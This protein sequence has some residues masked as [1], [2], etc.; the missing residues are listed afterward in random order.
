[1]EERE[2]PNY[3]NDYDATGNQEEWHK[4][5]PLVLWIIYFCESVGVLYFVWNITIFKLFN[6]PQIT[7]IDSI[8][9][10][11]FLKF[12]NRKFRIP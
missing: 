10:A 3:D 1:M 6:L 7:L 12:F 5:N 2:H 4:I 9:I 11:L 8:L